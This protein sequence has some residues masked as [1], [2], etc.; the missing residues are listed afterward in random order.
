MEKTAV[1]WYK[2]NIDLSFSSSLKREGS[3]MCIRND[4]S[5]FV[6][7]KTD[8]FALM[9]DVDVGEPVG[10]H[11]TLQWVSDLRFGN[12]DFTLDFKRVVDHVNSDV[13]DS[14]EVGCIIS[15][16]RRLLHNSF[17]NS[18]VE[19]NR[20]QVNEVAYELAQASPLNPNAH[21]IDDAPSC[22]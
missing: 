11:T 17:L 5:E 19:F 15:T 21:I 10:L 16:C 7:A 22:I 9:S 13:D 3:R 2:C 18:H 1:N 14:S 8:W 6:L 4:G 12:V 20:R